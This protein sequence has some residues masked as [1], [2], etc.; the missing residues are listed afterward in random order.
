MGGCVGHSIVGTTVK[1][2]DCIIARERRG[3]GEES[4]ILRKARY[5]HEK[6]EEEIYDGDSMVK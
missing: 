1:S 2:D 6:L 4:Y 5:S 3:V